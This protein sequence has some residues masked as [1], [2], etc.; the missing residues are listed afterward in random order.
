[1][2]IRR[3]EHV[4]RMGQTKIFTKSWSENWKEKE[5]LRDIR[6]AERQ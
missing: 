1:M 6:E 5:F 2:N 3:A 4:A